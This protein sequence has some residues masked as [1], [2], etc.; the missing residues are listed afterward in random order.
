MLF[1]DASRNDQDCGT[2]TYVIQQSDGNGNFVGE[3]LSFLSLDASDPANP[4]L[5]ADLEESEHQEEDY[6]FRIVATVTDFGTTTS[7]TFTYDTKSSC[8]ITNV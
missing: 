6:E 2:P 4:T 3:A 5:V 7:N 8:E 1:Q